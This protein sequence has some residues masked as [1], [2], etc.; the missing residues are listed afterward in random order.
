MYLLEWLIHISNWFSKIK[1]NWFE[2]SALLFFLMPIYHK[3]S[4]AK[5]KDETNQ[6]SSLL[7]VFF[8]L[9][10]KTKQINFI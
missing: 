5:P 1:L 2:V 4:Q 9:V 3:Y 6:I 8:P 10:D 7:D